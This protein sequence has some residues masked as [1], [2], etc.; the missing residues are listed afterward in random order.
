MLETL[1]LKVLFAT[2][3]AAM[4]ATPIAMYLGML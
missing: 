1:F 3:V 4:L 2:L